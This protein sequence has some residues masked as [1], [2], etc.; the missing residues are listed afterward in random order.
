MKMTN[1]ITNSIIALV[2]GVVLVSCNL[3]PV[4]TTAIVYDESEQFFQSESD[5]QHFYNGVLASYRSLC[6][7]SFEITT[8]VMV[9]YFNATVGF[10]NNYG[11]VHRADQTFTPGDSDVESIWASHYAAIKN[12][13]IAISLAQQ[14]EAESE[15]KP[16]ADYL[17]AVAYFCRASAYLTLTRLFGVEYDPATASDELSVPVVLEYDQNYTPVRSTVEQVYMQIEEDLLFAEDVLAEVPGRAGSMEPTADAVNALWARYYLDIH[18]YEDALKAAVS[19]INSPTGGYALA[20]SREDMQNEYLYDAGTE[21]VIQ[22]FASASEGTV[23]HSVY[24][25]VGYDEDEG[26]YFSPYFIPSTAIL[27]AYDATDLRYQSWFSS[28]KYPMFM[29]GDYYSDITIF[30]KYIGNEN[31]Y[32]GLIE[33]SVNAAKPIMISEMYLIA[34]EAAYM[35]KDASNINSTKYLN[36]LQSARKATATEGTLENIKKEWYREMIGSGHRFVCLKRWGEGIPARPAQPE[37]K[38]LVMEGPAYDARTVDAEDRIFNLPIPSYE[39][40]ITPSLEQ[41]DGYSTK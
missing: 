1:K 40:K 5:I 29:N 23:S 2:A 19:V 20:S 38:N 15:L 27:D 25:M 21:P 31:W 34:A 26:K 7:G 3:D 18:E 33:S 35:D 28:T 14:V 32:S 16:M 10:G 41:N 4:P 36:E 17:E 12:Y 11:P 24:T 37:A 22:L 9:D 39:I 13:N 6:S 8:D 30:T